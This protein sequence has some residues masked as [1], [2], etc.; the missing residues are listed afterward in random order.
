MKKIIK[1]LLGL[2]FCFALVLCAGLSVGAMHNNLDN[3][4]NNTPPHEFP[5]I[6]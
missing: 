5:P 2:T 1:N 4:K 6:N 3:G